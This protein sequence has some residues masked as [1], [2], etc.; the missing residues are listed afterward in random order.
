[1]ANGALQEV[2][3]AHRRVAMA[4]RTRAGA[5]ANIHA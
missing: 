1:M 5:I 3:D 4:E 2:R